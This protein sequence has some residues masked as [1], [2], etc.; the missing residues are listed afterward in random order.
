MRIGVPTEIKVLESRVGLTPDSVGAL[1]AAGHEVLVQSGAGERSGF[2]DAAYQEAGATIVADAPAVFA[3]GELIIKV[4]EPQLNEC[5]LLGAGHVLF[6]YLHLAAVPE[7]EQAL[8]D[9]G[10]TAIAYETVT[11]PDGRLPLLEPM[12]AVAGRLAV[13]AGASALQKSQGGSGVLISGA[14]GMPPAEVLILGAG[15][16]GRNAAEVAAGLGASVTI[17]DRQPAKVRQLA[18]QLGKQLHAIESAEL[19]ERVAKSDL[20]IG[21]A[22]VAGKVAPQ[23]VTRDMLRTMRPGSVVVDIAIDQGG[24]IETS[25]PTTLASPTFV[26]EGIVHY[27]VTNMPGDVPRTSTVALNHVTLPFVQALAAKGWRQACQDD[28]HLASG[29]S[30]Q[31]GQRIDN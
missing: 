22:L 3:Q 9:S 23:L 1:T 30:V 10:C 7:I 5:E 27:C 21:A 18:S 28:P 29:L 24:C 8:R 13:Q 2:S 31:G 16:A 12:S 25:R 15:V 17:L 20:V 11:S 4:K 26:E 14:A 6:T 19:A